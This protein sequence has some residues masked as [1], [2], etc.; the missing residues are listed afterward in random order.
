MQGESMATPFLGEI[1]PFAC[2]F[3]PFGWALCEGQLLSISQNT[4]LFSLLGTFYGGNGT[5][6]FALPNLQS[7]VPLGQGTA[8]TGDNY[9]LG[10]E[11]GVE[12]VTLLTN[13]MPLHTHNFAG[14]SATGNSKKPLSGV[15]YGTSSSGDKYYATVASLTNINP[16]TVS[17]V[18]SGTAHTNLQ[19]Y[20][21]INWCIA[22]TGIF[23][24][25]N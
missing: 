16:G 5:S 8:V 14:S 7:R 20:L 13:Q 9:V 21:A 10:E 25:R 19:P 2:N 6:N 17:I 4:A 23:P 1:R 18:G 22:M 3:A 15:A 24:S 11:A 12:N